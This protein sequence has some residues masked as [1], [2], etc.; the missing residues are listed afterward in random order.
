[1]ESN[2][3]DSWALEAIV[4]NLCGFEVGAGLFYRCWMNWCKINSFSKIAQELSPEIKSE[5]GHLE[6]LLSLAA[7]RRCYLDAA[8]I[9][10]A[11][12]STNLSFDH[13]HTLSLESIMNQ[14]IKIETIAVQEYKSAIKEAEHA[15]DLMAADALLN[16]LID[17]EKGLASMISHAN[18]LKQIGLARFLCT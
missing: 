12:K 16:I 8:K 14:A 10:E 2:R 6:I 4:T 7:T 5:E 9:L 17:E 3:E 15:C 18:L 1:M 11:S 13:Q